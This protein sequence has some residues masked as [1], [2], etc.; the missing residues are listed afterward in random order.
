MNGIYKFYYFI[1]FF[2]TA[3]SAQIKLFFLFLNKLNIY[4]TKETFPYFPFPITLI[5][6][7]SFIVIVF[8]YC[9]SV[10]YF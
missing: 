9:V 10:L 6:L 8:F 1:I 2:E 5:Y 4:R 3:L 7:K